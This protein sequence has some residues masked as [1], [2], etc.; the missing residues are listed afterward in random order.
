M[1][2]NKLKSSS[3]LGLRKQILKD[4]IMEYFPKQQWSKE[5]QRKNNTKATKVW[6]N[7]AQNEAWWLILNMLRDRA[8]GLSGLLRLIYGW[9][10]NLNLL[11]RF[12]NVSG[13][14]FMK[15]FMFLLR[16]YRPTDRPYACKDNFT[17]YVCTNINI[18]SYTKLHF[19]SW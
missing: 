15:Q 13:H 5:Y 7:V 12:K 16:Y 11:K 18:L 14:K 8:Q 1:T 4:V 19:S 17:E 2:S 10:V 3:S 6:E 9:R